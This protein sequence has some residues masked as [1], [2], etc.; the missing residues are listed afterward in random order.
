MNIPNTLTVMRVILSIVA[1]V[2]VCTGAKYAIAI[3][4]VIFVLAG[5]TDWF[6]GYLARKLN[7][8]TNLG[9]FMDA[10]CDKIMVIGFFM[11]LLGLQFYGDFMKFAIFC[12]FFSSAREFFVSGIRMMAASNGVVLAAERL[13]K[14]KAAFQMYSIGAIL[15][16]KMCEVDFASP[17]HILY[18]ISF[19]SG[20]ITLGISTVLSIISGVGY[21]VKYRYLLRG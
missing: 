16:A 4:F 13:G 21:G 10:L 2:L 9:K 3:S 19:Y 7:I 1:A 17:E 20:I 8:V 5:S 12:T 11:V 18:Y 6:D 15:F 14:Y